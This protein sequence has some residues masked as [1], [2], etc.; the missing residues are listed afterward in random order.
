M[1][2]KIPAVE[3]PASGC[4]KK[5]GAEKLRQAGKTTSD[6]RD[7]SSGRL[8]P[9]SVTVA[10][11]R[12]SARDITVGGTTWGLANLKAAQDWTRESSAAW[13]SSKVE[14]EST[15]LSLKDSPNR[16]RQEGAR[17]SCVSGHRQQVMVVAAAFS[18]EYCNMVIDRDGSGYLESHSGGRTF[19][20]HLEQ[21]DDTIAESYGTPRRCR[22]AGA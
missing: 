6:N 22:C 9:S 10:A 8:L 16:G 19:R 1:S 7:T 2:P 21:F 18:L 4:P 5:V 3:F 15:W 11:R 12:R 14:G 13:K 17:G 20:R